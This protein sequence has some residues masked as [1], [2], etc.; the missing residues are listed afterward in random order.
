MI[1]PIRVI[2]V[3]D[4]IEDAVQWLKDFAHPELIFMDIMLA[5]G[6]SFEILLSV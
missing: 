2:A 4:S 1:R 6:Q 5:D 3:L